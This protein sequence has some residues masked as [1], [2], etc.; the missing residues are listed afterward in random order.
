M[1][2]FPFD[3]VII[4]FGDDGFDDNDYDYD[5]DFDVVPDLAALIADEVCDW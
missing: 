1:D 4:D 5:D 2:K 3:N